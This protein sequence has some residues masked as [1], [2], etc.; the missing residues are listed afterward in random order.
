M[1]VLGF[2]TTFF[3]AHGFLMGQVIGMLTRIM[4]TSAIYNKASDMIY[5]NSTHFY[6]YD[7]LCSILASLK[8]LILKQ[9]P[10]KDLLQFK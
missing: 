1:V 2:F 4:M 7:D 9:F 5:T 10:F 8:A 6:I 3:H